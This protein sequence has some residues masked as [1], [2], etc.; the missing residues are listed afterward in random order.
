MGDTSVEGTA[1][2]TYHLLN[3]TCGY[4]ASLQEGDSASH[5]KNSC[6]DTNTL[7]HLLLTHRSVAANSL[8]IHMYLRG[9]I[10]QG[11]MTEHHYFKKAT[12]NLGVGKDIYATYPSPSHFPYALKIQSLKH[13]KRKNGRSGLSKS[14]HVR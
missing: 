10:Y 2:H 9:V 5:A 4:A 3:L 7:S 11:C 12:R 14:G 6:R 13:V 8:Y 1:M